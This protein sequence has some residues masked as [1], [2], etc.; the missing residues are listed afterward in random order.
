MTARLVIVGG[1]PAG[2]AAGFH[3]ARAGV[4]VAI[5][6]SKAFP[7]AKVCGEYISP[8]ATR[9]LEEMVPERE[10]IRAGARRVDDFIVE[11]GELRQ[12]WRTPRPAWALSRGALDSLL[13]D[14]A[15]EAGA[16]VFQPVAVRSVSYFDDHV[17]VDLGNGRTL[18]AA[19][20]VHA[21]GSGR[22]D[23]AGPTPMAEG[24]VGFKC[25][26]RAPPGVIEGVTMRACAGAYVGTIVVEGGLGTCAFA[27]ARSHASRFRTDTDGLL[28][29]LWPAFNPSWRAT[30]WQACGVPRSG[31]VRPGHPRSLRIG[32]AAAAVDPVGGEGI[33]LAI[34]SGKRVAG[35]LG[36]A[37]LSDSGTLAACERRLAG[38]YAKRLRTRLPACR[39]AA[40]ALMRPRLF[41]A[42]WPLL[43]APAL[44]LGPWYRLSGKPA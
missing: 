8:A 35:L 37:A 29:H 9:F 3:L 40:A 21:D 4:P 20:V 12:S 27:A 30:E 34:W 43:A 1:G 22:H 16:E 26:L 44:S 18:D 2:A 39:L 23:P 5:L 33:G 11:V 19:A 24:L 28:R 17:T 7:R 10:L 6:E 25:H 15:R 41:R 31:Y 14:A 42:L 13:L 38:E 32:N 36:G